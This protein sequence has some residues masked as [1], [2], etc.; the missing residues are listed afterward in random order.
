MVSSSAIAVKFWKL[1]LSP[2]NRTGVSRAYHRNGRLRFANVLRF[3]LHLEMVTED[4]LLVS[5]N[6]IY[7]CPEGDAAYRESMFC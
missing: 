4:N 7:A 3:P 5:I 6:K 1:L 2:G